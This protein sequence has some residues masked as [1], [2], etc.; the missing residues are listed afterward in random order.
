MTRPAEG[1]PWHAYR[2]I[3]LTG[4]R[5]NG[6]AAF[7]RVHGA[8]LA[9]AEQVYGVPAEIIVAIIGVET[10]YGGNTAATGLWTL[11]LPW[12]SIIRNGPIFSVRSWS[13]F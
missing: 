5:I 10:S 13:I 1:K 8:T 12:P 11:W 4:K 2:Q 7:W 3:F 9:R 6:G